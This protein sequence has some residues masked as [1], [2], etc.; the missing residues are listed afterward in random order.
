MLRPVSYRWS[1]DGHLDHVGTRAHDT[2]TA[3][4]TFSASAAAGELLTG[5]VTVEATDAD[6]MTATST[7]PIALHIISTSPPTDGTS[8]ICWKKTGGALQ[9]ATKPAAR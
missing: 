8:P 1:G 6:G 7:M 4:V 9:P 2:S 3:T 5:S